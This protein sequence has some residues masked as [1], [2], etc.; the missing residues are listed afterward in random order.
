MLHL[1]DLD[2]KIIRELGSPNFPQWNVKGSFS[3]ISRKLGVD[4]ETVR[5]RVKRAKERGF[6][7]E[8]Q[9]MVNPWLIDFKVAGLDLEVNNEETKAKAILQI[10]LVE[11]V[12]NIAD[13]RGKGLVV[14]IYYEN[15]ES[16]ERKVRLIES[17]C[18]SQRLAVLRSVF[19]R[20]D[21]KM[22]K[23]D[24]R[25]VG[26]MREDAKRDLEDVATSLGVSTRTVQRRLSVMKEGKAVFVSAI[27][28]FDAVGGVMSTLR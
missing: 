25:I 12:T 14:V 13:Y 23:V 18:G 5:M 7:P 27:P 19:P 8:W 11:G 15:D 2:V 26:V 10:R 9:M 1:D 20:P 6:L 22:R 4:E 24:W 28:K 17:I 16:L 3:N 21:V